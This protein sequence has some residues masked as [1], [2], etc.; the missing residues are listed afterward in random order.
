[1]SYTDV[2]RIL[3]NLKIIGMLRQHEKFS[4]QN[5]TIIVDKHTY[6]QGLR[7]WIRGERRTLNLE[8]LREVFN[9]AFAFLDSK[10]PAIYMMSSSSSPTTTAPVQIT[11]MQTNMPLVI[12]SR[13]A[14]RPQSPVARDLASESLLFMQVLKEIQNATKGIQNLQ[15]TYEADSLVVAQIQVML[16]GIDRRLQIYTQMKQKD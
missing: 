16:D 7:R 12:D 6:F 10:A 14:P 9:S 13:Y 3:L 8:F 11:S 2:E 15:T 4:T 1:M 5:N